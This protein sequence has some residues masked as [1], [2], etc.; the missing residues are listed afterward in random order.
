MVLSSGGLWPMPWTIARCQY[1]ANWFSRKSAGEPM[2]QKTLYKQQQ[3]KT[4][5]QIPNKNQ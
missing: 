1:S 2:K 3:Q 5:N 4:E